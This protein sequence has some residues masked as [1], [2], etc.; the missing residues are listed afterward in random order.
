MDAS[1]VSIHRIPVYTHLG[2][3]IPDDVLRT[4]KDWNYRRGVNVDE[5]RL[6]IIDRIRVMKHVADL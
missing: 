6:N 5:I 1:S 4:E 2:P 3:T